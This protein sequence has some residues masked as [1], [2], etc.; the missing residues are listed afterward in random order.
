MKQHRKKLKKYIDVNVYDEAKNR[1]RHVINT[2]DT[3]SSLDTFFKIR[4]FCTP[5]LRHVQQFACLREISH[6]RRSYLL[7]SWDHSLGALESPLL[8]HQHHHHH[9]HTHTNTH[10]HIYPILNYRSGPGAFVVLGGFG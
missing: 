8:Q 5:R 2:F 10:T 9:T 3:L 1:I 4:C 7:P 6:A